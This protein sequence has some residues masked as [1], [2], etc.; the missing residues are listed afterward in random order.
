[1]IDYD[2]RYNNVGHTL[3]KEDDTISYSFDSTPGTIDDSKFVISIGLNPE[4]SSVFLAKL[5][6]ANG[7]IIVDPERNITLAD[8]V[9]AIQSCWTA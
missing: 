5:Q 7:D 3:N 4:F 1:V 8:C 2:T 6:T 9:D